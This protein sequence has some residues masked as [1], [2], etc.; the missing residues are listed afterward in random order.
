MFLGSN[1]RKWWQRCLS[2]HH[3]GVG[4]MLEA[5]DYILLVP[6]EIQT[7]FWRLSRQFVKAGGRCSP[8]LPS[9]LFLCAEKYPK[10]HWF[11]EREKNPN[12]HHVGITVCDFVLVFVQHLSEKEMSLLL[13]LDP[14]PISVVNAVFFM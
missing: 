4:G 6:K 11:R 1:Q 2:C 14:G 10:T 5:C 13:V 8:F 7:H 3:S 9:P 12:K